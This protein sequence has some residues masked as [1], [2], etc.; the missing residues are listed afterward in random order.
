MDGEGDLVGL[1]LHDL[2]GDG[3]GF[4][5]PQALITCI[6]KD[7]SDEGKWPQCGLQEGPGAVVVLDVGGTPEEYRCPPVRIDQIV[8]L[9]ALDLLARVLAARPTALASLDGR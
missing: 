8:T 9:L 5:D 4:S 3:G 2:D 7:L 1:S 6:G